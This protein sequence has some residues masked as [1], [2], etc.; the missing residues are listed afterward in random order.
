MSQLLLVAPK[1]QQKLPT[2]TWSMGGMT[3]MAAAVNTNV[4]NGNETAAE[5]G[6]IVRTVKD[7]SQLVVVTTV[8]CLQY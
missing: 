8:Y 4:E 3:T 7:K 6:C 5:A 2:P 1:Q